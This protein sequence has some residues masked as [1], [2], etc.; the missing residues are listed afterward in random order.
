MLYTDGA[1]VHLVLKDFSLKCLC[2]FLRDRQIDLCFLLPKASIHLVLVL[3]SLSWRVSVLIQTRHRIDRQCPHL[4][5][6]ICKESDARSLR[7]GGGE[8]GNLKILTYGFTIFAQ[9]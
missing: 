3:K 5:R 9:R 7:G 6:R 4:D 1:S 8:L 2:W